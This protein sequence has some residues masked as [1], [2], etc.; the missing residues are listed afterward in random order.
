[1]PPKYP[2]G[3]F[4][5]QK[6]PKNMVLFSFTGESWPSD[7]D[8]SS[9]DSDYLPPG[10]ATTQDGAG[11]SGGKQST[12]GKKPNAK[13]AIDADSDDE[14]YV[15]PGISE[16]G[17]NGAKRVKG[18][19]GG[20]KKAHQDCQAAKPRSRPQ[21]N[22]KRIP[23]FAD[24]DSENSSESSSSASSA[25]SGSSDVISNLEDDKEEAVPE[26]QTKEDVKT[27]NKRISWS[28]SASS[29]IL[30]I[31]ESEHD[32]ISSPE[33]EE[34][35]QEVE[36]SS[37]VEEEEKAGLKHDH[38]YT[39]LSVAGPST[40]DQD[41]A[42]EQASENETMHSGQGKA[43]RQKKRSNLKK[44]KSILKSSHQKNDALSSVSSKK[45]KKTAKKHVSFKDIPEDKSP[46][47]KKKGK[48]QKDSGSSEDGQQWGQQLPVEVIVNILQFAVADQGAVPLLCRVAKVCH[49]WYEATK[50]PSLWRHVD[51]STGYIKPNARSDKT[52][53]WL[54]KNRFSQLRSLNLSHWVFLTKQG[55]QHLASSCPSLQHIKLFRC[56]NLTAEGITMLA[57]RCPNLANLDLSGVKAVA[58]RCPQLESVDLTKCIKIGSEGV[59][60]LADRCSKLCK[61]QLSSAQSHMV[62]PTCLKHVLEK[63]GPRLKELNLSSNK[64]VGAP[65]IFKCIARCPQLEVLDM[66]NCLFSS[67]PLLPIEALQTGCPL[68]RVLRLAGSVMAAGNATAAVQ[69]RSPGFPELREVSLASNTLLTS[70]SVSDNFICRLLKTSYKLK[71]LDLRGCSN[72][73]TAGLQSLPVTCLEQFFISNTNNIC[74]SYEGIETII[75]KCQHSLVEVDLSWNVYVD[76][77]LDRTLKKLSSSRNTSQLKVLNLSGTCVTADMVRSV[78]EGCPHLTSLNLTSCRAL[79]RGMKQLF[80]EEAIAELRTNAADML[81]STSDL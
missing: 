35:S 74:Y 26:R 21:R 66:S 8:G 46:V 38:D 31:V 54:A 58:E 32:Y 75:Q 73:N 45:N 22:V 41:A 79:P 34:K 43:I 36:Y 39:E 49:F 57:D 37:E 24:S 67:T 71:L 72:V 40:D 42:S 59:T 63:M 3:I 25:S 30:N 60:A 44:E 17:K 33:K 51:L 76:T 27:K 68:L 64:L 55:I 29:Q 28:R 80:G 10:E 61:I 50:H 6:D 9:D 62:S 5:V 2:R 52:L 53:Q 77:N 70:T 13:A 65:G 19:R 1:M 16:K 14:D 78:L 20:G 12:R 4:G 23:I 81:A 11:K 56:G 48:G 15:P 7:D 18:A 69:D 47:K